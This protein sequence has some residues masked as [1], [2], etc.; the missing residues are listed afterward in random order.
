MLKKNAVECNRESMSIVELPR[1]RRFHNTSDD[2]N[3][4]PLPI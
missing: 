2:N 1:K 3:I 4:I